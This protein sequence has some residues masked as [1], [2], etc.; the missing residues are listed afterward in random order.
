MQKNCS[1]RIEMEV[2]EVTKSQ[3]YY[4]TNISRS[5]RT[6]QPNKKRLVNKFDFN[7][8]LNIFVSHQSFVET[9]NLSHS[10]HTNNALVICLNFQYS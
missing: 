3:L 10:M 4:E 5:K 6:R 1:Y 2:F 7:I 9:C 8:D